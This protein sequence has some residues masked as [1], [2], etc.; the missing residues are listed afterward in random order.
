M[1]KLQTRPAD[2]LA[3]AY[4]DI[5]ATE[6]ATS[7]KPIARQ[8]RP[9]DT[10]GS[11]IDDL[12]VPSDER[13]SV[14][15]DHAAGAVLVARAIEAVDGLTHELRRGSPVACLTVHSSELVNLAAAVI[16][17][18]SFGA[19]ASILDLSS[20]GDAQPRP[21][22]LVARDGCTLG[23]TPDKG[24]DVIAQAIH[25]RVPVVGIATD[26][27]RHLPRDLLRACE[28]ELTLPALDASAIAL[29]VE[30]V[31]GKPPG[32]EIDDALLRACDVSDLILSI[33]RNLPPDGCIDRLKRIVGSKKIFIQDGPVLQELS[34][35]GEAKRWAMEL[36]AD[37]DEYRSG[38]AWADVGSKA[39]LLAGKQGVGK[40]C[41]IRAIAK[42]AGVPLVSIAVADFDSV[43]S[44]SG[45]P[46]AV[47]ESFSQAK[48]LGPCLLFIDVDGFS[49]RSQMQHDRRKWIQHLNRLLEELSGVRPWP[50][51][52]VFA[53]N[54]PERVDTSILRAGRLDRMIRIHTPSLE[55]LRLI[56]RFHLQD[57]LPYADLMSLALVSAG[58]TGADVE[59]WTRRARSRARRERRELRL[60]DLLDEIRNGRKALSPSLRRTIALHE[61]GHLVAGLALGVF[62]PHTLSISDEGG[63]T[64]AEI[65]LENLQT[66]TDIEN[67]IVMLL[68]GRACEEE[69]LG[70]S[71][72][73]SGASGD[74]DSD[75]A[76][77]TRAASAIELKL[78]FGTLG[79]IYFNEP[80]GEMMLHDKEVLASIRAR[81]SACLAR[82]RKL[83]KANRGTIELIA[84]RLLATGYLGAS[85]IEVLVGNPDDLVTEDEV[86]KR[87]EASLA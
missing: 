81:L 72:V 39:V 37:L 80:A 64:R 74:D 35:Y 6:T 30:A 79:P 27:K 36:T 57:A 46:S 86:Q 42:T 77:A 18:C 44:S 53:T 52:V 45:S 75:L 67:V 68:A 31:V 49:E 8:G 19:D 55:D 41:L 85:E 11:L 3:R 9:G 63:F 73:T 71:G 61:S 84:G 83:I 58:G 25:A 28:H 26:P 16:G 43:Q 5:L 17:K 14:R 59:S 4:L 65:S 56:F 62:A 78:G 29:I 50:V 48:R 54:S 2:R 87:S 12:S 69:F 40:K 60:E 38:L 34:G 13:A 20:F 24:N 82:A 21:V 33:H 47:E 10:I 22:L 76:K 32:V 23:D 51:V 15:A 70:P 7:S 1:K 66:L